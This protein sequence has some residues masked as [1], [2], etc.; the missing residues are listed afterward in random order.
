V[1]AFRRYAP[2]CRSKELEFSSF[3]FSQDFIPGYSLFT[4]P[5]FFQGE[6]QAGYRDMHG[7]FGLE[8]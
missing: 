3:F 7:P 8:A 6:E 5:A 2:A 1:R 4:P